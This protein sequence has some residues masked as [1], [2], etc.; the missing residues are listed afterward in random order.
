MG[1]PNLTLPS[2]GLF[3]PSYADLS[4]T[5]TPGG[6]GVAGGLAIATGLTID[7]IKSFSTGVEVEVGASRGTSGGRRRK[8]TTGQRSES[9]SAELYRAGYQKLLRALMAAAPRRG[10]QVIVGLVPFT[11]RLAYSVPGDP[12]LYETIC[13]GCRITGRELNDTEGSDPTV[14]SVTLDPIEIVEI[15]D[16]QE[17][18]LL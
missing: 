2:T 1:F 11:W 18:T 12:E 9:A 6:I 4:V 7:D 5:L 16:G 15:V 8:R 17:I 13:K 10:N 14:V 3:E